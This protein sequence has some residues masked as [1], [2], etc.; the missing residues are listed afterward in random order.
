MFLT[1]QQEFKD[2][3]VIQNNLAISLNWQPKGLQ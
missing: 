3:P 2:L 1:L